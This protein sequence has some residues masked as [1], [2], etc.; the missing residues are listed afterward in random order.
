MLRNTFFLLFLCFL[1]LNL[2][3]QVY[4]LTRYSISEGLTQSQVRAIY[5]DSR[6]FVWLGTHRGLCKFDG[7]NFVDFQ[8]ETGLA[9]RFVNAITED[10]KGNIWIATENGVSKYNGIRFE[11]FQKDKGLTANSILSLLC[12]S[13]GTIWMGTEGGGLFTYKNDKLQA[14]QASISS[15]IYTM[16]EDLS[17]KTIWIGTSTGLFWAKNGKIEKAKGFPDITIN[18]I[19]PDN[20][21]GLWLGTNKGIIRYKDERAIFFTQQ[22]AD[23][24]VYCLVADENRQIWAGT[25]AGIVCLNYQIS[26]EKNV[27]IS[28]RTFSAKNWSSK[29]AVMAAARDDEGNLWL[30]TEGEGVFKIRKGLFTTYGEVEGMNSNIIKSFLEDTKGK[31]WAS[32][33]N[34]GINVFAPYS[35]KDSQFQFITKDKGLAGNDICA[36]F[37]DSKGNFWFATYTNGLSCYNGQS[38][39]NYKTHDGLSS[40]HLY[41]IAEDKK[42]NIWVGS[43]KG[44]NVWDGAKFSHYSTQNGLISNAIYAIFHDSKG[45]IWFGTPAGIT[46]MSALGGIR[47]FTTKDSIS[48]NLVLRI[49]EDEK[50]NIWAATSRGICTWNGKKWKQIAIPGNTAANDVVAMLFEKHSNNLWLGTNY[51][52]FKM[53]LAQYHKS[54]TY[55]FEHYT[56]SDGL[57]SLECNANAMY[58]DSKGN[59]WIG[60]IEGAVCYRADANILKNIRLRSYISSIKL[61]FKDIKQESQYFSS[62]SNQTLLPENLVL[63]Y[64]QNHLTF[65]FIGICYSKPSAVR[66]Q[67]QLEGFDKDWLPLTD[68]TKF[69][70][71]NLPS[72]K[73]TFRVRA[74]YNL[75]DWVESVPFSFKINPPFWL[76]WWFLLLTIGIIALIGFGIYEYFKERQ[77]QKREQE[78]MQNKSDMLQLEQ[79]ALYAM[80]NPHFTFNALQSIQFFIHTQ[81]KLSATKFLTQFAKLVR[82]NLDSSKTDFINL[83]DEIERLKLYLSL[84]K[85][86]FQDKFD[87]ELKVE[88]GIDKSETQVPPMILQPFVENSLKHGIM[89]LK[90]KKGEVLVEIRHQDEATLLVI[91]QDNGIGIEASK[92]MKENRP[93]DHVSQGMKITHDRL[94]LF[95]KTTGK[96]YAIEFRELKDENGEVLGTQVRI[97][98]P[99]KGWD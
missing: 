3:A 19:L 8:P 42:G 98:L 14:I 1:S 34:N 18:A 11:N 83:N 36:S 13:E 80:M 79:Q 77:R 40:D 38:F 20:R 5:Q 65:D 29:N 48:D 76:T 73:Y 88:E 86:R 33:T 37:G 54:G 31:I 47:N 21:I 59:I 70:Y 92:K 26:P 91:I 43:D 55:T 74:T 22:V 25:G 62:I 56:T 67:I 68:E 28:S 85:M 87:Y 95:S 64:N 49:V 24:N 63:P 96:D 60:T 46:C 78:Q 71:S 57:P 75:R 84:E 2:Q 61:F 30:G 66:Y 52:V 17:T 53:D 81:D 7:K 23:K 4:N 69:T 39:Q 45:N 72:G 44:A 35:E 90:D 51:G 58:E 32:T 9:G 82:M 41:C 10:K 99:A 93:T 12:D 16:S 89:P 27:S 15:I 6:G 50:G 97:L 94:K